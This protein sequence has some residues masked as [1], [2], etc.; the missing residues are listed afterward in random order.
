MAVT[1]I[2]GYGFVIGHRAG[3]LQVYLGRAA[4]ILAREAP[5]SD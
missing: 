1:G 2:V 4:L 5:C 3:K